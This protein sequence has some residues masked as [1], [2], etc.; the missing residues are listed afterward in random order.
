M[1]LEW[2]GGWLDQVGTN[3]NI[4]LGNGL[5]VQLS[6]VLDSLEVG[7]SICP[8]NSNLCVQIQANPGLQANGIQLFEILS[9]DFFNAWAISRPKEDRLL[10]LGVS[11]QQGGHLGYF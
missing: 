6:N 3:A 8:N 5:I 11:I 2:P 4:G 10:S 7:S 1:S 9:K